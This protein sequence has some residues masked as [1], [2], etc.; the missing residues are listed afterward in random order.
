MPTSLASRRAVKN[1]DYFVARIIVPKPPQ[2]RWAIWMVIN[3]KKAGKWS[4]KG[5]WTPY[6][7]AYW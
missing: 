1:L 5:N 4:G 6:G 3:R 7:V 2:G